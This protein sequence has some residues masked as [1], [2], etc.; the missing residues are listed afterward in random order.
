MASKQGDYS[1]NFWGGFN[2]NDLI[3][4]SQY[5]RHFKKW[6][7][8]KNLKN[9]EWRDVHVHLSK[10]KRDGKE[11][12]LYVDGILVPSKEIQKETSRNCFVSL[13]EQHA[14]GKASQDLSD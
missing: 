11:S 7:F 4:K 13:L 9:Q 8:R 14:R 12:D 3:S 1:K 5:E 6:E 10:R 2:A